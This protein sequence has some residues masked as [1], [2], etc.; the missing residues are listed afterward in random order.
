MILWLTGNT[1]AGKTTIARVLKRP[2]SI[3]LDG[4]EIRDLTNNHDL[5]KTGRWEHN[6]YIARLAKLL[7]SQ[8]F[9]VIVSVI[10]PYEKLRQEVQNITNCEFIYLTYE[11]D[12]QLPDK[13]YERPACL[14]ICANI[15]ES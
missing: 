12:D 7:E 1:G 15:P 9:Q 5:S 6:L 3:L 4:D 2:D 14:S 13:P 11:G 8:G 10:C